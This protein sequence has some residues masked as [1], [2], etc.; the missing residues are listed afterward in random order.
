[1]EDSVPMI[2]GGGRLV[3]PPMDTCMN[4]TPSVIEHA[5][6]GEYNIP[7]YEALKGLYDAQ[8]L[9]ER[10]EFYNKLKQNFR[11]LTGEFRT[12]RQEIFQLNVTSHVS[13]YIAAFRELF[14]DPGFQATCGDIEHSASG[15]KKLQ[16]LF[17]T[18]P[19]CVR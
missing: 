16:K 15:N 4:A 7:S 19:E 9:K 10:E 13:K 8:W 3:K 2:R 18:L 1:M 11:V 6:D 12:G 17:I 14:A 5:N